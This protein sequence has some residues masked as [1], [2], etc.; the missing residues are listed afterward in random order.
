[1]A[2]QAAADKEHSDG[3]VLQV[4]GAPFAIRAAEVFEE[5]VGR[6]VE[7]DEGALDE[8]G[9]RSPLLAWILWAQV[10]SLYHKSASSLSFVFPSP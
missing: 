5:D 1:M 7:E 9:R 8:L 3:K 6:A 2:Y 10:P 4:L